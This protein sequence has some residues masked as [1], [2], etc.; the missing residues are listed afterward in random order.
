MFSF[1]AFCREEISC[2]YS[3]LMRLGRTFA[4]AGDGGALVGGA[5]ETGF[6]GAGAR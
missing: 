5:Q 6:I 1:I 2:I 3:A 4:G